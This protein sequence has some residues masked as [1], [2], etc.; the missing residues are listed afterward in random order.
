MLFPEGGK[1]L[2]LLRGQ[3]FWVDCQSPK[4]SGCSPGALSHNGASVLAFE[5]GS[6]PCDRFGWLL[7]AALELH[8]VSDLHP[9]DQ[10]Q[11]RGEPL[12]HLVGVVDEVADD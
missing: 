5:A 4:K 11:L 8:H 3:V 9:S 2:K 6:L 12:D 7:P 10:W 1:R